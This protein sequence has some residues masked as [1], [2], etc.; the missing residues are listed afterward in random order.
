MDKK[1]IVV[2]ITNLTP[3][4]SQLLSIVCVFTTL[5]RNINVTNRWRLYKS[6]TEQ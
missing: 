3:M 6:G 1:P 4:P 5:S 2:Y